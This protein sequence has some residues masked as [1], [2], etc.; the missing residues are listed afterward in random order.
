MMAV[1]KWPHATALESRLQRVMAF[2]Y[3][4][5]LCAVAALEPIMAST[6][7]SFNSVRQAVF[8]LFLI[9]LML[10][11]R[12]RLLMTREFAIYGTFTVYMFVTL[13]WAPSPADGMNTLIPAFNFMLLLAFASFL[14][15]FYPASRNDRS[16]RPTDEEIDGYVHL[17]TFLENYLRSRVVALQGNG[18]K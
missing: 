5:T 8:L 9:V 2:L 1:E 3:T 4:I 17:F 7:E 18:S 14:A 12:S 6:F 10:L 11:A 16:I 13:I 15:P